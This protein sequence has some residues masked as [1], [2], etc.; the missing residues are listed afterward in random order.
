MLRSQF[1]VRVRTD[2]SWKQGCNLDR[3][4][5]SASGIHTSPDRLRYAIA[6][7]VWDKIA[8]I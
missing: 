7:L 2:S 8:E 5:V 4:T 1:L 6:S 3:E